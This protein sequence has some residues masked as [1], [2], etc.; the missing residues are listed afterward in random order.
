M[1]FQLGK[2]EV[3]KNPKASWRNLRQP[4]RGQVLGKNSVGYFLDF[5]LE[6]VF[7]LL[8]VDLNVF[9]ILIF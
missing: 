7:L 1:V 3:K 9:G 2:E 8:V 6:R 4:I 5:H